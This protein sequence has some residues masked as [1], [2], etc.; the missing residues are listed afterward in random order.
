MWSTT[1][2]INDLARKHQRFRRR[3]R[4]SELDSACYAIGTSDDTDIRIVWVSPEPVTHEPSGNLVWELRAR[5]LHPTVG[6]ATVIL[7]VGVESRR[8]VF[9]GYD[10]Y[11]DTFVV[12]LPRR[13]RRLWRQRVYADRV[14]RPATGE[15]DG[16]AWQIVSP[17]KMALWY[18]N[19]ARLQ[20]GVPLVDGQPLGGH[21]PTL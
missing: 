17:L 12:E 16:G 13:A 19:Y 21:E 1:V 7:H 15:D 5:L 18:A 6:T 9:T 3:H 8:M 14:R 20:E 10:D 2:S 4:W 11:L